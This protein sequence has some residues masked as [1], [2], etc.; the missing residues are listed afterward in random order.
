M[1]M[2]NRA[3]ELMRMMQGTMG[4]GGAPPKPRPSTHPSWGN[5][6]QYRLA[7]AV[8]PMGPAPSRPQ[9]DPQ[10]IERL[11]SA[12][13][14]GQGQRAGKMA[15]ASPS[16]GAQYGQQISQLPQPGTIRNISN[17]SPLPGPGMTTTPDYAGRRERGMGGFGG[18]SGGK[19]MELQQNGYVDI[20]GTRY[21]LDRSSGEVS[22]MPIPGTQYGGLFG[23]GGGVT[24]D[25]PS[26]YG[27]QDPVSLMEAIR[28]GR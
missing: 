24:T 18:L 11:M 8:N 12:V 19:E 1:P 25:D 13:M 15:G 16:A 2:P 23:M 14:Q 26:R 17:A 20:G 6:Q 27:A 28:Q 9:M 4:A 3:A 5:T 10:A 21:I 7:G 22:Q